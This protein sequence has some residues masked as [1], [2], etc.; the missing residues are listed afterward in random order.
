MHKVKILYYFLG[1]GILFYNDQIFLLTT[2][3]A[4]VEGN[5]NQLYIKF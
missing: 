3:I 2:H 5:S 4:Q 1:K